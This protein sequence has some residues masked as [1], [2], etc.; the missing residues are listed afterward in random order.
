MRL[1]NADDLVVADGLAS[2]VDVDDAGVERGAGAVGV[3]DV[4]EVEHEA[5]AGVFIWGFLREEDGCFDF[6][7]GGYDELTVGTGDVF[8]VFAE[9][10]GDGALDGVAGAG[11]LAV[12]GTVEADAKGLA[13]GEIGPLGFGHAFVDGLLLVA[14]FLLDVIEGGDEESAGGAVFDEEGLDLEVGR[15]EEVVECGVVVAVLVIDVDALL[16]ELIGHLLVGDDDAWFG[17]VAGAEDGPMEGGAA[18]LV[19]GFDVSAVSEDLFGFSEAVEDVLLFGFAGGLVELLNER[20][21]AGDVDFDGGFFQLVVGCVLVVGIGLRIF[22]LSCFLRGFTRG[23][24]FGLR[25]CG[26]DGWSCGENKADC[27]E[28]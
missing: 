22:G 21:G 9:R 7:S 6:G 15:V 8:S 14:K 4:G 11:V 28:Q 19:G 5:R 25:D 16:D 23:S 20:G 1:D 13:G 10:I 2:V 24:G 17:V 12:D 26:I 18:V 3:D 27:E